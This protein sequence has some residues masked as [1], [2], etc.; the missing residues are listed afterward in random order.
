MNKSVIFTIATILAILSY[1]QL[2]NQAKINPAVPK[3]IATLFREWLALHGK[4][5]SGPEEMIHRLKVFYENYKYVTEKNSENN[6]VTLKLNQ[7]ADLH[8]DEFYPTT[9]TE[10]EFKAQRQIEESQKLNQNALK[11][12]LEQVP[13]PDFV[14]WEATS[15][16]QA[17]VLPPIGQQDTN[18]WGASYAWA[19]QYSVTANHSI[20]NR[21]QPQVISAQKLLD[22]FNRSTAYKCGKTVSN[23]DFFRELYKENITMQS[24]YTG[25][26]TGYPGQ[27]YARA[28]TQINQ[29][30]NKP[31]IVDYEKNSLSDRKL[32]GYVAKGV[33]IAR[34]YMNK[35][36]VQFYSKGVVTN[37]MCD[38]GWTSDKGY[39]TVAVTGYTR[40][41]SSQGLTQQPMSSPFW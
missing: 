41:G 26:R 28:N 25:Q 29:Q 7:F 36:L 40:K 22:C 17:I 38:E 11:S 18:C 15:A 21:V 3:E 10:A 34:L 9:Q 30:M 16:Q 13:T 27:C 8:I 6:G 4:N 20:N 33:T 12:N 37:S 24:E 35:K 32:E 5:Y 39:F 31:Y 14:N 1:S 2:N 23:S 19:A